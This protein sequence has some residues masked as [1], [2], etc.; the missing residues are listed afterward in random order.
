M[1]RS[2]RE[3]ERAKYR[4]WLASHRHAHTFTARVIHARIPRVQILRQLLYEEREGRAAADQ[5]LAAHAYTRERRRKDE[6]EPGLERNSSSRAVDTVL[7]LDLGH[8]SPTTSQFDVLRKA[9]RTRYFPLPRTLVS[10]GVRRVRV[11]VRSAC[12]RHHHTLAFT[13]YAQDGKVE[14]GARSRFFLERRENSFAQLRRKSPREVYLYTLLG[15]SAC[16]F[17]ASSARQ[18]S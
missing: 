12:R 16:S 2:E 13:R 10:L 14:R 7:N 6:G 11:F 4:R 1:R 3:R 9:E 17:F 8:A 18:E 5:L 15:L